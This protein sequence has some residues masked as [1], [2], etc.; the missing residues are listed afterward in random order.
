MATLYPAGIERFTGPWF[1][2]Y[3]WPHDG[4]DLRGKRVA[5]VGTGATGV[6][7]IGAIASEVPRMQP[8]MMRMPRRFASAAT[9]KASVNPPVLSS[10]MLINS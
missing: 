1:H 8:V 9:A 2:T 6:Q 4:I 10:L 5:V 3:D 7:I